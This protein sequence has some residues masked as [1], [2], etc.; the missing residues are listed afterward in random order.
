MKKILTLAACTA[1]L[2]GCDLI[3]ADN[4]PANSIANVTLTNAPLEGHMDEDGTVDLYVEVQDI[5]GRAYF[6]SNV[7]E[8]V[9]ELPAEGLDLGASFE[10]PAG[11]R[12]FFIIV[13]DVDGEDYEYIAVSEG[14][15]GDDLAA[16]SEATV[17]IGGADAP[18]RALIQLNR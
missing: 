2:A 6:K 12:D 9:A 13:A 16:S 11:G 5:S 14:F 8:N 18:V 3:G 1:L 7:F 15:S 17:E 4:G 10:I